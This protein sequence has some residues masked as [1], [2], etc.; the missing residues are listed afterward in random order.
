M[1]TGKLIV[2]EGI[3]GS[4]IT[5][6]AKLLADKLPGFYTKEPTTGKVGTL[7]RQALT[8]EIV[9]NDNT[10][11]LLFAAD[12]VEHGL[13]IQPYLDEGAHV[14]C[15]RNLLSSLVYQNDCGRDWVREIN[16]RCCPADLTIFLNVSPMVA[17][18]RRA[19]RGLPEELFEQDQTLYRARHLFKEIISD[20]Q[21]RP[22]LGRTAIVPGE[23]TVEEVHGQ[24][25]RVVQEFLAREAARK[26]ARQLALRTVREALTGS[27][28]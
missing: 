27:A 28:S 13:Q 19:E 1:S 9:L 26:E 16:Q 18:Q 21:M 22:K 24:V 2:L 6:Q 15:D 12:R 3:D 14:I 17:A 4:G 10:L 11:A 8:K 23:G 5:T 20:P 25:M 7:I